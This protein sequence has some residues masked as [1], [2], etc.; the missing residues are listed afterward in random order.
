MAVSWVVIVAAMIVIL[1]VG[2]IA[3]SWVVIVA[4]MILGLMVGLI[5]W[6]IAGL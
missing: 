4:A 3:V 5:A 1:I 2:L 6:S